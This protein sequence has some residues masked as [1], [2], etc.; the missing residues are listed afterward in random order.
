MTI[1]TTE[2]VPAMALALG[3]S[4]GSVAKWREEFSR[5]AG[6]PGAGHAALQFDAAS[7]AL[8][9]RWLAR[10]PAGD[11]AT[12]LTLATPSTREQTEAF[13]TDPGWAVAYEAYQRVVHDSSASCAADPAL[14]G[15]A[16]V[17]DVR[18]AGVFEQA[19]TMLPNSRWRDPALVGSWGAEL[20]KNHPVL[21]YCVYGHEVGRSTALRLRAMG[22]DALYLPG[23]IDAWQSAGK[24]VQVKADLG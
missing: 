17:L 2:M 5:C 19:T 24:P 12:L 8:A 3:A 22:V 9:N 23:G 10:A 1:A 4:F 6:Q 18:R 21:V 15:D 11:P 14:V 7:G 20:P 16:L 13:L